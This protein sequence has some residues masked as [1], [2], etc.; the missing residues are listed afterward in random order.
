MR[1]ALGLEYDGSHFCGWQSQPEGCGVQ[2]RLEAALASIAGHAL[3]VTA[4]G[5][6]DTGVHALEQ[7]V[8]F[9]TDATRPSGAWVRGVNAFLPKSVRV[10]WARE[11]DAEFHARFCAER[12]SYTYWLVNQPIAPAIMAEKAGWF[13]QPLD[14]DRMAE[15]AGLLCGEHD[16]SAFRAAE[17]QARS[18][19]KHMYEASVTR[20]GSHL[21]F[22]FS[23]NAF[24][25]HQ[26][27]NMVGALVYIGKGKYPPSHMLELLA[28][29]DRTLSPPTFSAGGLYLRAVGYDAKWRIPNHDRRLELLL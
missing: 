18:P 10:H 2:D 5:R 9:D 25:H 28:A 29:R 11:V 1:I 17:C 7:V 26:V 15:A 6:T 4:A 14:V 3:R 13:H 21:L 16:F 20:Q 8:H 22:D 12:R 23:A 27:R 24:L 19:I